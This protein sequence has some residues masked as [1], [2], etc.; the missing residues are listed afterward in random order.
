ME[1]QQFVESTRQLETDAP[2]VYADSRTA[3]V[4]SNPATLSR[5]TIVAFLDYIAELLF[6]PDYT[7]VLARLYRPILLDLATRFTLQHR[8]SVGTFFHVQPIY[9]S[10]SILL[11]VAPQLLPVALNYFRQSACLFDCI[12][13]NKDI[14]QLKTVVQIS[15]RLL[16][17]SVAHFSSLWN[18]SCFMTLCSSTNVAIRWYASRIISLLLSMDNC[19]RDLF[20]ANQDLLPSESTAAH[21]NTESEQQQLVRIAAEEA[22]HAC[23]MEYES[24]KMYTLSPT[25][26]EVLR[27]DKAD[28]FEVVA[29]A[30][31]TTPL[32]P[33]L[34]SV[35]GVLMQKKQKSNNRTNNNSS[36]LWSPLLHTGS[37]RRNLRALGMALCQSQPVLVEGGPGSGKS[38][39]IRELAR[40]TNNHDLVEIQVLYSL[41]RFML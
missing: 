22:E 39:L 3:A 11:P 17:F 29:S 31:G 6:C 5:N 15:Y 18:W 7:F 2:S 4:I 23:L 30:G 34:V 14:Q 10:W 38:C 41:L 40:L 33:S 36:C 26:E 9:A 27:T 8:K 13:G 1:L 32:H 20:M 12:S 28:T 24:T 19:Q 37:T 16:S 35:A 25:P 21:A